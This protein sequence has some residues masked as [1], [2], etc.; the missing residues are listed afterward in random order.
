MRNA[1]SRCPA[2]ST[3]LLSRDCCTSSAQMVQLSEY[4]LTLGG[5]REYV[6]PTCVLE[7]SFHCRIHELEQ[8]L[9]SLSSELG[10]VCVY[11]S[12]SIMR[13]HSLNTRCGHRFRMTPRTQKLRGRSIHSLVPMPFLMQ[14][15]DLRTLC[16][17]VRPSGHGPAGHSG[18]S[19][20]L[21]DSPWL[22]SI[23]MATTS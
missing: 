22:D 21:C 13:Y 17:K 12:L 1:D 8:Q 23:T 4:R 19:T 14:Y 20:V 10:C 18:P 5:F 6:Y 15:P 11:L 9:S 16:Y 2:I 7:V 3:I